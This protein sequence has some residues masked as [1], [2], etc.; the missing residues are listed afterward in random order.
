MFKK[1]SKHIIE[2]FIIKIGKINSLTGK[3]CSAVCI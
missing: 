3:E 2:K 1:V